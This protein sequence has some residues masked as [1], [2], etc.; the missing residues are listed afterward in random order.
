[1]FGD[2]K[3]NILSVYRRHSN[4]INDFEV[5]LLDLLHHHSLTSKNIITGDFVISALYLQMNFYCC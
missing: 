2:V 3:L 5:I 4:I 1:M